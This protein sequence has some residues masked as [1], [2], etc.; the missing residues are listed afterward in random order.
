[1]VASTI[2]TINQVDPITI[3]HLS[4]LHFGWDGDVRGRT[5]RDLALKGLLRQLRKIEPEWKPEIVCITGDIGWKG[6]ASDYAEAEKWIGEVLGLLGLPPEAVFLC[7]GNHDSNR[8]KAKLNPRPTASAEAD[9]RLVIPLPESLELP[10]Q[11]FSDFSRSM[12]IPPYELG[13]IESFTVGHRSYKGLNFVSHNSAWYS[14]GDDDKD[15]LWIGANFIKLMESKGQLPHPSDLGD[16]QA[17]IALMHHPRE[18]FHD[19]ELHVYATRP[20]TFEYLVRRCHLLLTGHTHDAPRPADQFAEAAWHLSGGAAYAGANHFNS[21]R[22]IK[23]EDSRF[24]YRTFEY[25]PRSSDNNWRQVNDAIAIQIR[26]RREKPAAGLDSGQPQQA[27]SSSQFELVRWREDATADA[28][29]FV[30]MKSRALKG[31]EQLPDILPRKVSVQVKGVRQSFDTEGR[32]LAHTRPDLMT[33]L[34]EASKHSRRTLLLGDL[35]TGKS[36]LAGEFVEQALNESEQALAFIVPA[37]SIKMAQLSTVKDLLSAVAEYFSKQVAPAS[38]AIDIEALLD[39][40]IKLALVVDGLDEVSLPHAAALLN[41]LSLLVEN[42]PDVNVVATAR[43]VE[44]LGV[45]YEEWQV[46]VTTPLSEEEKYLLFEKEALAGGHGGAKAKDVAARLL[47]RLRSFPNLYTLAASPLVVRLLYPKLLAT[48]GEMRFTLGDLL[49]DLV[50]ERLGRWT[51][52]DNKQTPALHFAAEYPDELSRVTLFSQLALGLGERRAMPVEEARLLLES[53]V[54]NSGSANTHVLAE[55]ALQFLAQSGAAIIDEELE[56]PLQPFFEVLCGFGLATTWQSNPEAVS[57]LDD[58]QWRRFSF[59]ATAVRRLG[60]IETLRP[61][62][63]DFI[64]RILSVREKVPAAAYVVAESR[65]RLCAE[66]FISGSSKIGLR[67]LTLIAGERRGSAR[68]VAEAIKL[69]GQCGFDWFFDSYLDPRYPIT[70]WGTGYLDQIFEQWAYLSLDGVTE[71]EREQLRSM[72]MPH[73]QAG[74]SQLID[75]IPLIALLIPNDFELEDRLWFVAK[76]LGDEFFTARAEQLLEDAYV[77]GHAAV[78]NDTLIKHARKGVEN[79]AFAACLWL[80]LN[81]NERPTMEI[82]K[83]LVHAYGSPGPYL[84]FKHCID[85]CAE[86][87]GKQQWEEFL[88]GSLSDKDDYLAAG[89]ALCLRDMDDGNLASLGEALLK[90]LHDGAYVRR[91]EEHLSQLVHEGG[92]EATVWLAGHIANMDRNWG[93][94]SGWWRIFLSEL[95][96]LG[97]RG[98]RL[99]AGCV[100]SID[101]LL[102]PRHPEIRQAFRNLLSGPNGQEYWRTLRSLLNGEDGEKKYGAAMILIACE[103]GSESQALEIVVRQENAPSEMSRH[104]WLSFC[105]TLSFGPS[106]LANVKSKLSTLDSLAEDFALAILNRNGIQ[107]DDQERERLIRGLSVWWN[108][109]LDSAD[110][111]LKVV[112]QE[113]SFDALVKTVKSGV[114]EHAIGA[115]KN[116]IDHH[117]S[118]LPLSL[119][120]RCA[121][122]AIPN[123][124]QWGLAPMR[125]HLLRMEEDQSYADTVKEAADEIVEQGG[126]RPLLDI[127]RESLV[128]ELVWEEVLKRMFDPQGV[129]VAPDYEDYGQWILDLGKV[130]PKYK[131]AIGNAAVKLLAEE[132]IKYSYRGEGRQWLTI[133]ADEF[134]GLPKEELENALQRSNVIRE[135]GTSVL[136]ARLGEVPPEFK[137]RVGVASRPQA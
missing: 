72:I 24:V 113:A 22:L 91:A 36:T 15:R 77:A 119:Y 51:A 78:V 106:V 94:H 56:F 74:T 79:A 11:A 82:M 71:R 37:K 27:Q 116:L 132:S 128:N 75:I 122:L 126:E 93:G 53:L 47:Q 9:E 114:K 124:W 18:W 131:K 104:E 16:Y 52:K 110:P 41:R 135:S 117:S 40:R 76:S 111:E 65:D 73:I 81:E 115:A 64:D 57:K 5:D 13:D 123:M 109:G 42:W 69:A 28:K 20:S 87:V 70:N 29:R 120:A 3:L 43:P 63:T 6:Q 101:Y 129:R 32:L 58:G 23:V 67:P 34:L 85:Q 1:M 26:F 7:P 4:D 127:L 38:P 50:K 89:A 54:K 46:L 121:A 48:E 84:R 103:P 33:S 60:N 62:L 95:P 102:L 92:E 12:N 61:Q 97:D 90:A 100:G 10:F 35:G 31:R 83:A 107:L 136:L 49:Y 59:A 86:R 30:E 14:Q 21:F 45:N 108:Y 118:K 133:I 25:D 125:E 80:K 130:A 8:I 44:L 96:Q 55:E 112:A 137:T 2:D 99:L 105:M 68:V 17:T 19:E 98:P 39:K 134:V 88:W 66:A